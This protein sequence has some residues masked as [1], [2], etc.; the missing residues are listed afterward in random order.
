MRN[1]NLIISIGYIKQ[2]EFFRSSD[3]MKIAFIS[4]IAYD[5]FNKETIKEH[6][7]NPDYFDQE[8]LANHS[9]PVHK[10]CKML[11]INGVET[12]LWY[13]SRYSKSVKT[14]K[15]KYGHILRRIF[16]F[17]I[18]KIFSKYLENEIS[19][20]LFREIRKNK[21]SHVLLLN[22]LQNKRI[23]VDMSDILILYCKIFNI[24]VFPIYG[25]DSIENYFYLKK[26]IKFYFLKIANKILCQSSKEIEYMTKKLGYPQS[27]I[28]HFFNPLDL[29]NFYPITKKDALSHLLYDDSK[30]YLLFIGRIEKAKG[31]EHIINVMPYLLMRYPEIRFIV[32]GIGK[33][34]DFLKKKINA[35]E[36]NDKVIILNYISN[37]DII[38]FYNIA[39]I[40]ILPSYSEGTP[41]VL[42]EALACNTV[43][44]A[45]NVG[46][47]PD[48][49]SDGIGIIIE[50]KDEVSLRNAI[51]NVLENK[52]IIN[53]E[54]RNF[55]LN[56]IKLIEKGKQLMKIIQ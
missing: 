36:I 43:C 24:K 3:I 8:I 37:S 16:S 39:D 18:K 49:L 35:L 46:G 23:L 31:I 12:E 11:I 50:P 33:Y 29:E 53:Q 1:Y 26:K 28:I 2:I 44:I 34:L 45:T 56:N 4:L 22:Y 30:K 40:F 25:G 14:F 19:F 20:N 7:E 15:H 21:I 52:F 32:I 38:W 13:L 6:R 41:N 47:I 54:K 17:N 48:I 27:K 55:L 5:I 10:W 9:D 51:I 42:L